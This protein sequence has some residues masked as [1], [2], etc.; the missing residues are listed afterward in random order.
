LSSPPFVFTNDTSKDTAVSVFIL[1]FTTLVA[2]TGN[3]NTNFTDTSCPAGI[4][5]YYRAQGINAIGTAGKSNIVNATETGLETIFNSTSDV[6]NIWSYR[7]HDDEYSAGTGVLGQCE[8][9]PNLFHCGGIPDTQFETGAVS[10]FDQRPK[11][12]MTFG[13]TSN[14]PIPQ[15]DGYFFKTFTRNAILNQDIKVFWELVEAGGNDRPME[16]QV[17]DGAYIAEN[18]VDFP[19]NNPIKLK[20]GGL[21]GFCATGLGGADK[22]VHFTECLDGIDGNDKFNDV[23]IDYS[24]STED[25]ITVFF[26]QRPISL[27]RS[28]LYLNNVTITNVGFWDFINAG[29]TNTRGAFNDTRVI[30]FDEEAGFYTANVVIALLP[31]PEPITD[32]QVRIENSTAIYSTGASATTQIFDKFP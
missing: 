13:T 29:L 10:G 5:C 3:T 32:L 8:N 21:L 9:F 12:Q 25:F 7:V 17:F 15:G 4:T 23:D 11:M 31:A 14:T 30:E 16:I 1:N 22:P 27:S 2:D 18:N 26:Q 24:L 6:N 19:Y 28:D 20:G